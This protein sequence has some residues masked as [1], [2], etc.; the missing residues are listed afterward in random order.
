MALDE[1][2]ARRISKLD[3]KGKVRKVSLD[4][5]NEDLFSARI[6]DLDFLI[7]AN[8]DNLAITL[9]KGE[10]NLLKEG[11][12]KTW[13]WSHVARLS[14]KDENKYLSNPRVEG[15]LFISELGTTDEQKIYEAVLEYFVR[16]SVDYFKSKEE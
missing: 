10:E 13:I 11:K 6:F 8:H 16:Y 3:K 4:E 12:F 9:K 2:I 5:G 14:N 7:D 1:Y 15:E